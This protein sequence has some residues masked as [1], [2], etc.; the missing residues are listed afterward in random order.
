MQAMRLGGMIGLALVGLASAPGETDAE[1]LRLSVEGFLPTVTVTQQT[2]LLGAENTPLPPVVQ[3]FTNVAFAGT[4]TFD[5]DRWALATPD[6]TVAPGF[7]R[8]IDVDP[9]DPLA[10]LTDSGITTE[11]WLRGSMTLT[12]P[13]PQTV[14]FDRD[15]VNN[16]PAGAQTIVGFNGFQEI[17]Y[18]NSSPSLPFNVFDLDTSGSFGYIVDPAPGDPSVPFGQFE[19]WSFPMFLM[20]GPAAD[21]TFVDLF[22]PGAPTPRH[23]TA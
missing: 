23:P 6:P 19:S 18:Q 10:T 22:G 11:E 21:G 8:L 2:T 15:F 3:T 16:R 1:P 13:V 7:Q 4:F 9:A 14:A 12:L 5:S 20:Q 17:A